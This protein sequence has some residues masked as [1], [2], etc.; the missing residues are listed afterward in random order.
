M[1]ITPQSLN[2]ILASIALEE[3]FQASSVMEKIRIENGNDINMQK[4]HLVDAS[5]IM[6]RESLLD[7]C[8]IE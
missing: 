2:M 7:S 8:F 3:C 1:F 5:G 4:N 6:S